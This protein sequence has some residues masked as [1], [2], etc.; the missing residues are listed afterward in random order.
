MLQQRLGSLNYIAE[1]TGAAVRQ[2]KK[3]LL[4]ARYCLV[5]RTNPNSVT[6]LTLLS[7]ASQNTARTIF[8][9][10]RS[11][12]YRPTAKRALS[13]DRVWPFA[14]PALVSKTTIVIEVA[15]VAKAAQ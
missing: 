2:D 3:P 6:L 12:P 9:W 14:G 8:Q 4:H 11:A 13:L 5:M 15:K 1:V 7:I 10:I